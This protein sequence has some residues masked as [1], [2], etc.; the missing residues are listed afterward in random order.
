[1]QTGYAL[2]ECGSVRQKNSQSILIK[3]LFDACVGA[4]GFWLFGYAFAFGDVNGG[5]IGSNPNLYAAAGFDNL[6]EDHFLNWIFHF[7]FAATS[8][9]IV[10]GALAERCQL[11]TY[12]IFSFIQTSF[13]Y[14]IVVAWN[15]GRGWLYVL[16]FHDFAGA[17]TVHVVGGTAALWGAI[18]LGERYGKSRHDE[19]RRTE[20]ENNIIRNSVNF[21]GGEFQK[22]MQHVNKDYR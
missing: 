20:R 15:W 14:P 19:R 5:F 6:R 4:I 2:L 21:E 7:S 12:V 17:T 9:T 3:N 11:N 8:S 22:I 18:I 10:Q 16:G 13:I 1:M